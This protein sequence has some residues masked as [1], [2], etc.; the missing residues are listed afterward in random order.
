MHSLSYL[1]AFY[2]LTD[3]FL[4]DV[5]DVL[6]YYAVCVFFVCDGV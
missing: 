3:V 4:Y 1:A 2:V 6:Y 5:C